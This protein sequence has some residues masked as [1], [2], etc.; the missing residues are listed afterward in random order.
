[1]LERINAIVHS[2]FS[3]ELPPVFEIFNDKM[4]FIFYGGRIPRQSKEDFLSCILK[5][6]DKSILGTFKKGRKP[7]YL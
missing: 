4:V 1:M 6:H 5:E 7:S 2:G 3:R